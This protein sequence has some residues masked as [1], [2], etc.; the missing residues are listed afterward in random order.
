M[1][2]ETSPPS[3]KFAKDMTALAAV[4]PFL[5]FP[6]FGADRESGLLPGEFDETSPRCDPEVRQIG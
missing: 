2:N 4:K 1:Q 6:H 3:H 5:P